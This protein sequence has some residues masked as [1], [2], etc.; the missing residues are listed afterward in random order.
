MSTAAFL[1][2]LAMARGQA[3][4]DLAAGLSI[5]ALADA[6]IAR[7]DSAPSLAAEAAR[8]LVRVPNLP[9]YQLFARVIEGCD[10]ELTRAGADSIACRLMAYGIT[11]RESRATLAAAAVFSIVA[12]LPL[13]D[14]SMRMDATLACAFALRVS[15]RLDAAQAEYEALLQMAST[16]GALSMQLEAELGL[17]KVLVDRGNIP[18]AEVALD[19]V[20]RRARSVGGNL[21]SKALTDAAYIAGVRDRPARVIEHSFESLKVASSQIERDRALLNISVAMREVER[22]RI[23]RVIAEYL[24]TRAADDEMRDAGAILRCHL[25]IDAH[26]FVAASEWLAQAA[27]RRLTHGRAFDLHRA[28]ARMFALRGMWREAGVTLRLI[29]AD[30]EAR[31]MAEAAARAEQDLADIAQCVVPTLY[32]FR[33]TPLEADAGRAVDFVER[34][35]RHSCAHAFA[36]AAS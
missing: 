36:L 7:R 32:R 33:P 21:L 30:A 8:S 34:E 5:L 9:L 24:A 19:P 31:Q 6:R 20:L 22:P 12:R 16:A 18:A 25:A 3:W 27:S 26:D 1:E 13:D 17:V 14:A 35:L 10:V 11:L 23:S 2:E 15:K 29:L 28:A 4:D